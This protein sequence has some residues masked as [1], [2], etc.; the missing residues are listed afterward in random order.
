M[1]I[2]P[3]LPERLPLASAVLIYV[4]LLS[5]LRNAMTE[6]HQCH[7]KRLGSHHEDSRQ[8]LA[9]YGIKAL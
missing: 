4:L 8:E 3:N 5:C 7:K 1:N 6:A 2:P 9:V